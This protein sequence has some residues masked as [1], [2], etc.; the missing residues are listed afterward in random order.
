MTHDYNLEVGR[1]KQE[2]QLKARLLGSTLMLGLRPAW[3]HETLP[4]KYV[5]LLLVAECIYLLGFQFKTLYI[6][7]AGLKPNILSLLSTRITR[8]YHHAWL[9]Y[10]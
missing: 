7:E 2:D 3:L 4:Q 6:T 1:W 9:L 10:F 8:M 5:V